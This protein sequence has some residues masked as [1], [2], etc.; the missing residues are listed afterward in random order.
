MSNHK[1]NPNIALYGF[2]K[3]NQL[4]KLGKGIPKLGNFTSETSYE[5][6]SN[7]LEQIPQ[8]EILNRLEKLDDTNFCYLYLK[9]IEMQLGFEQKLQDIELKRELS[10]QSNILNDNDV[11]M[12]S[13]K[14]VRK[15]ETL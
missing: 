13:I 2:Q 15:D 9:L 10:N 4:G 1:G 3:G 14:L 5:R 6:I 8:E 11:D 12:V 7:L